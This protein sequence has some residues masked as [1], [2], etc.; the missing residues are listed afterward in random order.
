MRVI[1]LGLIAALL[2]AGGAEASASEGGPDPLSNPTLFPAGT[3]SSG[4]CRSIGADQRALWAAEVKKVP[5]VVSLFSDRHIGW[6]S[7]SP[8][9]VLAADSNST[10]TV[11]IG[12]VAVTGTPAISRLESQLTVVFDNSMDDMAAESGVRLT[13]VRIKEKGEPIA[14]TLSLTTLVAPT[15]A[16]AGS[17]YYMTR[18]LSP[19]ADTPADLWEALNVDS[20]E[21]IPATE[22]SSQKRRLIGPPMHIEPDRYGVVLSALWNARYAYRRCVLQLSGLHAIAFGVVLSPAVAT[23][24]LGLVRAK[25]EQRDRHLQSAIFLRGILRDWG[26]DPGPMPWLDNNPWRNQG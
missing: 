17:L 5:A 24:L 12:V 1:A 4:A 9:D 14:T 13:K 10:V 8:V 22:S 19:R 2:L 26:R 16:A 7:S 15:S 11:T 21:V 18:V 3:C 6:D 25:T 20:T 23:Y